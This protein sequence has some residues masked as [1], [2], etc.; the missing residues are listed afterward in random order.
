[1]AVKRV[2]ALALFSLV[3]LAAQQGTAAPEPVKPSSGVVFVVGGI[4]GLDPL[5]MMAKLTLPKQ[6]VPHELREFD[7]THGKMRPLRDL[8]DTRYFEAKAGDLAALIRDQ[9][10][11]EPDRP[12]Y[13]IGHS[14]GAAMVLSAAA[15]LPPASVERIILLSPA[16]SPEYDLC[17]ALLATRAEIVSF[18]SPYDRFV[19]DLGTS[20]FGTV[21]RRYEAAAGVDGFEIPA[22]LS[23]T[24]REMYQRLVQV[25]W[26]PEKLLELQGGLHNSSVMPIFLAKQV[27]P[28][29]M[30]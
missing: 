3:L 10:H 17:P 9:L 12:I 29:L 25:A 26:R 2:G 11:R 5:Y 19:L 27:K 4:T 28:W 20:I 22:N 16:V 6:G 15:M 7:W 13:L 30:K 18:N 21:D 14:A 1:M 8:Q 24:D 23:E